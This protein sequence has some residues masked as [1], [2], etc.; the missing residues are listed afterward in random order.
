MLR[1][2]ESDIS[3]KHLFLQAMHLFT[4]ADVDHSGII[5]KEEFVYEFN[6]SP[7]E[8]IDDRQKRAEDAQKQEEP[9]TKRRRL[10]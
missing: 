10:S 5:T 6:K 9:P 4:A 7:Q 2:E 1:M 3:Q 8:V